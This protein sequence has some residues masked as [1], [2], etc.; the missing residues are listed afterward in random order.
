[1]KGIAFIMVTGEST[2]E[3]V[4]EA[5]QAGVDDYVVKPFTMVQVQGKMLNVLKKRK[6]LDG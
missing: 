6:L 5:V 4:V 1:M 3:R 2:K